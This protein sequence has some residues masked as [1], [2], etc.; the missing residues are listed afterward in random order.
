[1]NSGQYPELFHIRDGILNSVVQ[2]AKLNGLKW[3]RKGIRCEVP[4]S[5]LKI[6]YIKK[7]YKGEI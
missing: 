6:W 1:M 3:I 2:C 5:D 7:V 4:F